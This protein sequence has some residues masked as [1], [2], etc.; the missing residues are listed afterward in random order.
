MDSNARTIKFKVDLRLLRSRHCIA[1]GHCRGYGDPGGLGQYALAGWFDLPFHEKLRIQIE[2]LRMIHFD[3]AMSC[4]DP[5][6]KLHFTTSTKKYS[7]L[8]V[9]DLGPPTL[10]D[11]SLL[12]QDRIV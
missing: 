12:L 1:C 11:K 3:R 8:S 10:T 2:S 7:Q 6:L 5:F 4:H 9:T